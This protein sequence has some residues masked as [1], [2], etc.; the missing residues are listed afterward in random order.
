MDDGILIHQDKDYLKACL[1]QMKTYIREERKLEFNQKTQILPIS[2]GVD[3]LGFHFYL[4]DSG[5][6]VRKLRDSN[7]R[8]MKRKLKRYR[9]AYRTGKMTVDETATPG[10]GESSE[11]T[12]TED[13][14]TYSAFSLTPSVTTNTIGGTASIY[15]SVTI[16]VKSADQISSAISAIEWK[17]DNSDVVEY[18]ETNPVYDS[19][20]GDIKVMLSVCYKVNDYGSA[21]I[22][23][24]TPD[25]QTATCHLEIEP[26][27]TPCDD[28][29]LKNEDE[30]KV[31]CFTIEMEKANQDYL[32][33]FC[34]NVTYELDEEKS[35]GKVEILSKSYTTTGD[36]LTAT[37]YLEV[38][39]SEIGTA[40]INITSPAKGQ[41]IAF[42]IICKGF[43]KHK[44]IAD[45]YSDSDDPSGKALNAEYIEDKP[46]ERLVEAAKEDGV[47][48][49]LIAWTACENGFKY[50]SDGGTAVMSIISNISQSDIYASIILQMLEDYSQN[51]IPGLATDIAA[52]SSSFL[53]NVIST[54]NKTQE[55]QYTSDTTLKQF[56]DDGNEELVHSIAQSKGLL[57]YSGAVSKISEIMDYAVT[58]KDYVYMLVAY[59]KM[60]E[61]STNML[62]MLNRMK[63]N[64]SNTDLSSALTKC[65]NI[66]EMTETQYSNWE[67]MKNMATDA[68]ISA[69]WS[70]N[71]LWEMATDVMSPTVLVAKYVIKGGYFISDLVSGTSSLSEKYYRMYVMNEI[72]ACVEKTYASYKTDYKNSNTVENAIDYIIAAEC[73]MQCSELNCDIAKDYCDVMTGSIA[74][75]IQTKLGTS[76]AA[77][78][79]SSIASIKSSTSLKYQQ[80]LTNWIYDLENDYPDEYEKY[81][82]YLTASGSSLK[83]YV[84]E[85]PVDV[86]VYD[87]DNNLAAS[88]VDGKVY[89]NTVIALMDGEAKTFYML[90]GEEYHFEY[91]GTDTGTMNIQ[92]LEYDTNGVIVKESS[93][94]SIP[95]TDGCVYT[96]TD[97]GKIESTE[98][99]SLKDASDNVVKSDYESN[100]SDSDTGYSLTV[101]NG[102]VLLKNMFYA[103]LKANDGQIL[104]IKAS[105]EEG[106]SFKKWN[107]VSGSATINDVNSQSTT[108][109]VKSDTVIEAIFENT[110]SSHT[111]SWDEGKITKQPTCTEKGVKTYTCSCGETKTEDILATGHSW[112]SGVITKN[113]TATEDGVKTYTCKTCGTT[114]TEPIPK[115]G[116]TDATISASNIAKTYSTKTQSFS[117]G[118]KS[119]AGT[120]LT[121][122]S[123]NKNIAVN[124][125]TGKVTVKAKYI[126]SAVIII[127]SAETNTTK[128]A[129]KKITVTVNPS[130]TTLSS[131]SNAKGKKI[132]VKWKKNS[133]GNGY[134]IQYSTSSKFASKNKTVTI[135]KNK[136]VT[137]T[138]SKLT[139]GKTYYVRIRTYKT[140]AGKNYY[141]GWS[142]VKKVKVTK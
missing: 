44:Y 55:F 120:A 93:F 57:R 98:R 36:G 48:N 18:T 112:N 133:I 17:S 52:E 6:V 32:D 110:D 130:K 13:D 20:T 35:T 88:I 16:T 118:A 114:K 76:S 124:K 89:S 81:K 86:Y 96:S 37:F 34:E 100:S 101:N 125:T 78:A 21:N 85:C 26:T 126:G 39:R 99:Y 94:A 131:A 74:G 33:Q 119:S 11:D 28:Y 31:E 54:V 50:A 65:I 95:L 103:Q 49:E 51:E 5:K 53:D 22:T 43:N 83:K 97:N 69:Q 135:K 42:N 59:E 47:E 116:K 40:V 19:G 127:S 12:D 142:K 73:L 75:R 111:H 87:S 90:A 2:Q 105:A 128:A 67:Y 66:M 123:N 14:V 140:V 138:I 108:I 72:Q 79:A 58:I 117:I 122:V 25:G 15:G 129:T 70:M 134:Q 68:K 7:K 9:H 102:F 141:S 77:E 38:K 30:T 84:I 45:K 121:Y 136:T 132:K 80:I 29:I 106:K 115:L 1:K 10:S 62:N 46:C 92:I 113:A 137:A 109:L 23:G 107:I 24:T 139:K 3:Y 64:T 41:E 56:M 60:R 82:G 8:R 71:R 61:S 104:A 63:S 91:K 27:M 4:T